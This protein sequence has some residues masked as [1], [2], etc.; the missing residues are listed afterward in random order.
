MQDEKDYFHHYNDF[1][2]ILDYEIVFE[3]SVDALLVLVI[4]NDNIDI[5]CHIQYIEFFSTLAS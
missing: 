2:F 3:K 5:L 1:D 4:L